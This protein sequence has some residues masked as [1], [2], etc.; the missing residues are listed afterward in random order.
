MQ[1]MVVVCAVDAPVSCFTW[2]QFVFGFVLALYTQEQ[3]A[4]RSF[5][6]QH[7]VAADCTADK[8]S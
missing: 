6:L 5:S 3:R 2:I 8:C 1:R 7:P 4:E